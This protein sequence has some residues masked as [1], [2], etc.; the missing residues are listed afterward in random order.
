[1]DDK[2][3]EWRSGL[4]MWPRQSFF[5]ERSAAVKS[6]HEKKWLQFEQETGSSNSLIIRILNHKK[7]A[8]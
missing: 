8:T 5:T 1:M 7:M 2:Y 6:N 3:S 4:Q